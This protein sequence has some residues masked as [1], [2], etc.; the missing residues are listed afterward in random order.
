MPRWAAPRELSCRRLVPDA[1]A[2]I[3]IAHLLHP[4]ELL[5]WCEA[6]YQ[7]RPEVWLVTLAADAFDYGLYDL[8]PAA[9]GAVVRVRGLI[10]G[11]RP[12][13]IWIPGRQHRA[14]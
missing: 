7:H 3:T 5:A 8:S 2:V 12:A 9:H 4:R 1:S 10:A 13:T 11:V 14:T 6:L